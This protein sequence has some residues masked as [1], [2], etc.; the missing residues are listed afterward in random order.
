MRNSYSIGEIFIDYFRWHYGRGFSELFGIIKNFLRFAFHFF[1]I[2][3]LFKTFFHP[4]RRMGESY[5]KGL[6]F[7]VA[8]SSLVVNTLM[9]IVG[10]VS[11]FAIILLGLVFCL[12]ILVLGFFTSI[13]W[14]LLPVLLS[15]LLFVS[16]SIILKS[17]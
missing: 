2:K 10:F 12:L 8:F 14:L 7:E 4:W 11:R 16:I 5:E 9:R 13:C 3:L 6:N 15:I 1:S 17:I